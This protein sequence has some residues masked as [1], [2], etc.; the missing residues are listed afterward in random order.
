[1]KDKTS[2]VMYREWSAL[3]RAMDDTQL[4]AVMRAIFDYQD[5]EEVEIEDATAKV[6]FALIKQKF[7][8]DA[9][10]Y[11]ETCKRKAEGGRNKGKNKEEENKILEDTSTYLKTLEDSSRVATDSDSDFELDSEGV[12]ES[13]SVS[14]SGFEK[15]KSVNAEKENKQRKAAS[16]A[17]HAKACARF[18]PPTVDEVRDYCWERNNGIDA[19]DFVDFYQSK[20][21]MV[22]KNKMS[23]WKASVRTW[24][25]KKAREPNNT[26]ESAG[27]YLRRIA[28]GG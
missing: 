22:G 11:E 8:I 7:D 15:D 27:E 10:K 3:F 2:Y 18:V 26:T 17:K 5:G 6:V 14:D 19:E 25:R 9:A 24:E 1:M 16:A 21:W 23:D 20:N 28:F 4:G 13:V 12:S